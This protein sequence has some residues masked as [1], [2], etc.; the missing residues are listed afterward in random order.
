MAG[1]FVQLESKIRRPFASENPHNCTIVSHLII[2]DTLKA[3]ASFIAATIE[4]KL[5]EMSSYSPADI[6]KDM[7]RDFGIHITY[8]KAFRAK[9]SHLQ[10]LN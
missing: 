10:S 1:F 4:E 3:T 8:S 7:R 5:R 6:V 9:V 2:R